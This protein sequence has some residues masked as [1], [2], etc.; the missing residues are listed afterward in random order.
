MQALIPVFAILSVTAA[1]QLTLLPY[2]YL[3]DPLPV[4]QQLQDT[5][6]GVHAYSYAGGPSAKEEVRGLDGVTRGSYSYVDA[7]GILQSVFYVAD[8][9]GFRVAATNLPTDGD[10]PRETGEVLLAKNAH[11]EEHARAAQ[12]AKEERTGLRRKRS[13]EAAAEADRDNLAAEKPRSQEDPADQLE[14]AKAGSPKSSHE[15]STPEKKTETVVAPVYGLLNPLLIPRFSGAATSHQSRVDV[16]SNIRL[17]AVQP[18]PAIGLL[19][20]PVYETVI[21]PGQVPLASSHQ[22][23]VQVH[24]SLHADLPAE[25]PTENPETAQPKTAS[26]ASPAAVKYQLEALPLVSVLH[27]YNEN[28]IQLHKNLGLEGPN[29]KDAVKIDPAPLTIVTKKSL[30]VVSAISSQSDPTLE[31]NLPLVN[32]PIAFVAASYVRPIL[33]TPI[34]QS[35]QYRSQI[36]SSEKT[37]V[38]K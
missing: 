37:E 15:P 24:N 10:L 30:P 1:A 36:H 7:H 26:Q 31:V 13:I 4:Y 2:A 25:K 11:L 8:E 35:A 9:G 14:P 12:E 28:R 21:L 3:A 38:T 27:D 19:A 16:H 29:R 5:R 20:E 6:N 17:K 23:R 18:V 22:S 34:A 33:E 32:D